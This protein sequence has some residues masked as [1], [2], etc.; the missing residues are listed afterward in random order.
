[1][2]KKKIKFKGLQEDFANT[3]KTSKG[4][5]E[6]LELAKEGSWPVSEKDLNRMDIIVQEIVEDITAKVYPMLEGCVSTEAKECISEMIEIKKTIEILKNDICKLSNENT[7]SN[8]RR[9][10][11]IK[12]LIIEKRDEI[13]TLLAQY[14]KLMIK[15]FDVAKVAPLFAEVDDL[16][17][18]HHETMTNQIDDEL[19][20]IRTKEEMLRALRHKTYSLQDI[21]LNYMRA[22]IGIGISKLDLNYIL[23]AVRK[24]ESIA[25]VI[26][27]EFE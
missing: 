26:L 1:M 14:E 21:I 23:Q 19:K 5:E 4:Y 25:D 3:F 16:I 7:T 27:K 15:S 6:N 22:E 17:Y 8:V 24:N 18:E 11:E 9:S 13:K 12:Y 2:I 20:L 10:L